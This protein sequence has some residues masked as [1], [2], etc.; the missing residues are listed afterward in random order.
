MGSVH[1]NRLR[2]MQEHWK[3]S[4]DKGGFGSNVPDGT[5]EVKVQDANLRETSAE[6]KLM[7]VIE[8]LIID[9]EYSGETIP[10]FIVLETEFGPGNLARRLSD[11]GIEP[12]DD[13]EQIEESL[14][15]L[16]E[17]TGRATIT[18]TTNR[19]GYTGIRVNQV[20]ND[21]EQE[22]QP[23]TPNEP[24]TPSKPDLSK[25]S[26]RP[27]AGDV[28]EFTDGDETLRATV[29]KVMI[30]GSF[31]A[32]SQDDEFTFPVEDS[33]FKVLKPE[34]ASTSPTRRRKSKKSDHPV[35]DKAELLQFCQVQEVEDIDEGDDLEDI[36]TKI[37]EFEWDS[38][39]LEAGELELLKKINAKIV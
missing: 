8:Y 15:S 6:Q 4:K 26:D 11:F 10:E 35:V 28:I 30:D 34:K 37:K 20:Y 25:S 7:A 13:V 33:S 19:K 2:A 14:S 36:I 18:L 23:E 24:D 17:Q 5:Y 31:V 38:S 27:H 9:G 22:S 16:S 32:E 12:P 39:E 3:E 29:T 1:Q 21:K